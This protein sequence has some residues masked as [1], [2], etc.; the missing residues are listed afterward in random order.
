MINIII[1]FAQKNFC[2]WAGR[3]FKYT[4]LDYS[5]DEIVYDIYIYIVK[6]FAPPEAEDCTPQ[7]CRSYFC[8]FEVYCLL[9]PSIFR[10]VFRLV[11]LLV[12]GRLL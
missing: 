3:Q 10:S 6:F 8:S 12:S 2:A 7:K 1:K 5:T 4:L 9:C 11:S